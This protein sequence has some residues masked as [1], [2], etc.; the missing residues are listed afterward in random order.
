MRAATLEVRLEELGVLR[1]FSRPRVSNDN[2]YSAL[3]NTGL[4]I[5]TGLSAAK[6]KPANGFLLLLI[7]I[8]T[9]TA[10]AVRLLRSADAVLAFM[11]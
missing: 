9:N 6:K 11:S 1:S 3:L 10:I 7:G 4:T 2:P 8:T 5:P